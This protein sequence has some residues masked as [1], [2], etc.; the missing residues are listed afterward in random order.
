MP[1]W[2]NRKQASNCALTTQNRHLSLHSSEKACTSILI[3]PLSV[4]VPF[5]EKSFWSNDKIT[6]HAVIRMCHACLLLL[7]HYSMPVFI[8][9]THALQ[10][11]M[12]AFHI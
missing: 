1:L 11:R 5:A 8:S 7:K 4:Y 2:G 6:S 3:F 10:R 9:K 12:R